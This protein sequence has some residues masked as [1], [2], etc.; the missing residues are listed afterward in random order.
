MVKAAIDMLSHNGIR[1]IAA[2][3][4]VVFHCLNTNRS[5]IDLQ[6]STLMPLFFLLSGF[7]LTIGYFKKIVGRGHTKD[8]ATVAGDSA[9]VAVEPIAVENQERCTLKN[10][11]SEA[12]PAF[13]FTQFQYF[14]ALRVMPVYYITFLLAIPPVLCGFGELDPGSKGY[15]TSSFITNI[16][17]VNT[18]FFLFLG[19][20]MDGPSWTVCTL[21]FFWL[22]FPSLLRYYS[23]KSD[24]ELLSTILTMWWLQIITG[25]VI[26]IIFGMF[27]PSL[28]FYGSTFWPP[29]RLPV[30]VMGICAGILVLRYPE[31]SMPW[32]SDGQWYLSL[33]SLYCRCCCVKSFPLL[34]KDRF[35]NILTWQSVQLLVVTLATF[36]IDTVVRYGGT[37]GGIFGAFWLQL[38]NP[39]AQLNLI[40]ALSRSDVVSPVSKFLQSP[41]LQWLGGISMS[42]YL[43]HYVLLFYLRWA[44]YGHKTLEWP[45]TQVCAEYDDDDAAR[46]RCHDENDKFFDDYALPDWSVAVIL[47]ASILFAALLF[48]G[49]EEPLRKRFRG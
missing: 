34:E 13:S 7:S 40:V 17:P 44:L 3:W 12:A 28:A 6:G 43:I 29:S 2:V 10:K 26:F 23:H 39:F 9:I 47:P 4:I 21:W 41:S 49:V 16:I 46:F 45:T 8:E 19:S 42:L 27:E 1:G 35:S 25:V 38:L 30:F 36:V 15:I 11:G 5:K 22:C 24:E 20:P 37:G 32:F 48:Y 14:R 18:W 33:Q 31:G